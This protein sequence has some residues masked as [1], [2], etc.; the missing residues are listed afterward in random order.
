MNHHPKIDET[1]E[2]FEPR[3][4]AFSDEA[5]AL[6]FAEQHVGDLRY[7]AAWG[8][9]LSWTGTNWKFDDTLNAF[10]LARQVCREAAASCNKTKIASMIASAKTVAAVER[11]AK[12]DRRIAATVD[13]WDNDPWLLNT[14]TGVIDLRTGKSRPARPDDY[15]TKITEMGPGGE[16]PRFIAFLDTIAGGDGELVAYLRRTLGYSLT[17]DTRE[18]SLFFAYGTGANGKSVLLST[19]AGILGDYHK[20]ARDLC[21]SRSNTLR[22]IT[23][24]MLWSAMSAL[25]TQL[26]RFRSSERRK[27][28]RGRFL[29]ARPCARKMQSTR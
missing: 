24:A 6:R 14:P 23:R 28:R 16:C 12:A 8:R 27:F 13:Q 7:V 3:P 5:L 10:D 9:W 21:V 11:L 22:R 26:R 19:M 4:P 15:I 2:V 20:T 29:A 17:G 1:V 25:I 18:H